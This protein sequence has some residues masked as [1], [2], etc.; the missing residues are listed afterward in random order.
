MLMHPQPGARYP[1][2][3]GAKRTRK[4]EVVW[5][6]ERTRKFELTGVVVLRISLPIK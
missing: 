2:F 1:R 3:S 5:G 6:V 4:R